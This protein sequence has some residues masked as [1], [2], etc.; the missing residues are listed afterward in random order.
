VLAGT[1]TIEHGYHG[2][3]EVFQMMKQHNVAL[4]PTLEAAAS[5][6]EY[7]DNWKRDQPFNEELKRV[8]TAFKTALNAGVTIG[9]GSDVGVFTHGNNYKELEW[10]VKFGMRPAQALLAATAVNA[11]ILGQPDNFGQI[12]TGL[13]ADI[14]AVKGDPTQDIH[15]LADVPF[16]MKGGVIYKRP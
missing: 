3:R 1:D 13:Y 5:Y 6:A 10:M 12:K 7:F 2:T 16:V 11:K 15:V 8:E 14:I 9:C 4:L